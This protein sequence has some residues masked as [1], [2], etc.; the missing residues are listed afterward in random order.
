MSST[1]LRGGFGSYEERLQY[2]ADTTRKAS[3]HR[4]TV[5]VDAE[6]MALVYEVAAGRNEALEALRT[7]L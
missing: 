5:S 4:K 3:S 7:R 6:V 2:L 1:N